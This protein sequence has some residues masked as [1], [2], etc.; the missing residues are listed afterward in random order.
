MS[1]ALSVVWLLAS[2]T[3][4]DPPQAVSAEA[5]VEVEVESARDVQG[6]WIESPTKA[7]ARCWTAW[8][9]QRPER[10]PEPLLYVDTNC[11][12]KWYTIHNAG[13]V[14]QPYNYVVQFDYPWHPECRCPRCLAYS[15]PS[16]TVLGSTAALVPLAPVEPA[17]KSD[18]QANRPSAIRRVD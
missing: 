8:W 2:I 10:L 1:P 7:I 15:I 3:T 11:M 14:R 4:A 16:A 5:P 6:V 13:S 12:T 17:P 9:T 18:S